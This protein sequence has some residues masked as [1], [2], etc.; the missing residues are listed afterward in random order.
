[1]FSE[2][3]FVIKLFV[4]MNKA[5]LCNLKEDAGERLQNHH[6]C[7]S[8]FIL[9]GKHKIGESELIYREINS[10]DKIAFEVHIQF[11]LFFQ[12]HT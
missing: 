3:H 1:M 11:L 9:L 7:T 4:L 10:T 6:M 8:I 5:F 2:F 12:V